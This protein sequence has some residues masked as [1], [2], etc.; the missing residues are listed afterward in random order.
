MQIE[1]GKK[2]FLSDIMCWVNSIAAKEIWEGWRAKAL[3]LLFSD[4]QSV[5]EPIVSIVK[6]LPELATDLLRDAA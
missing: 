1:K 2:Q 4:N 5:I 3:N 6:Q